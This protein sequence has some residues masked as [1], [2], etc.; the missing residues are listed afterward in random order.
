M[1][2]QASL[3][4][5]TYGKLFREERLGFSI[6]EGDVGGIVV[7][8]P[9]EEGP[10]TGDELVRI[11]EAEVADDAT[12]QSVMAL[13]ERAGRPVAL[14]FRGGGVRAVLDRR[15][16]DERPARPGKGERLARTAA[17]AAAAA[18]AA[19]SAVAARAAADRAE[20]AAS[21]LRRLSRKSRRADPESAKSAAYVERV[22][23]A[24]AHA[25][26]ARSKS[27]AL[28][29]LPSF[30]AAFADAEVLAPDV[31][32]MAAAA[33]AAR[34]DAEAG[35]APALVALEATARAWTHAAALERL[36]GG[37]DD[38]S[39]R[40][41]ARARADAR[42]AVAAVAA[43]RPG[44]LDVDGIRAGALV[45]LAT[46]TPRFGFQGVATVTASA[47]T[48]SEAESDLGGRRTNDERRSRVDASTAAPRA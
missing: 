5:L 45:T 37:G 16:G 13:L 32:A 44:P 40:A 26:T 33:A 30:E 39:F 24:E 2:S 25:A 3:S 19:P 29:A 17:S 12:I 35:G 7:E 10:F 14:Y 31:D 1:K 18:E 43:A 20:R 28:A 38:A 46:P 41:A 4:T 34:R 15:G 9:L 8:E 22:V 6:A 11:G 27:E 36:T 42:A 48:A 23:I 21:K 47:G